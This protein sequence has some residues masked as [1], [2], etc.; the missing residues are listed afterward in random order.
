MRHAKLRLRAV[1]LVFVSLLSL[2][3]FLFPED[4]RSN[5]SAILMLP[6]GVFVTDRALFRLLLFTALLLLQLYYMAT[7]A[8]VQARRNA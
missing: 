1:Q 4:L 3:F 6:V 8:P 7:R 2:C 5:N